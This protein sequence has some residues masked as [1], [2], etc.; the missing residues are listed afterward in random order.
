MRTDTLAW[1]DADGAA[2]PLTG[3]PDMD[4]HWALGVE[5]R[6]M[7]PVAY[8]EDAVYEQPGTRLRSVRMG[9]RDVT[10]PITVIGD[11]EQQVRSKVRSLLRQ[12]NPVR[13]DGTLRATSPDGTMRDLRCRYVQGMEGL[14]ARDNM[15][16]SFL[17]M[18]LVLHASS[19][20][21]TDTAASET[22]YTVGGTPPF[23]NSA[24]L[25]SR[26]LTSDTVLGR[27]VITNDGDL[28]AYPVFTVAGP[29]NSVTIT[30][31]TTGE[32]IAYEAALLA[33]EVLTIDTRP[34][35]K[36]VTRE[37]GSNRYAS[38]S[39]DSVLFSLPPGSSTVLLDVPGSTVD[40]YAVVSYRRTWLS[41]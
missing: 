7:P 14:E 37:D 19:P 41:P 23:L 15:G 24:W 38:L 34:F 26:W 29:A 27:Q 18:V 2:T 16:R 6:F 36:T 32:R 12:F 8:T 13:G 10:L 39:L 20:F 22:T 3:Q 11:D 31:D 4:V 25:G 28:D 35:V 40:T 5:G 1:I 33:G 21:W 30:N 17:R 9:A